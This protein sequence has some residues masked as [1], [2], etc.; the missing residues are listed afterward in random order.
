[1]FTVD[2]KIKDA[3]TLYTNK[4][5]EVVIEPLTALKKKTQYISS[6]GSKETSVDGDLNVLG[7]K[8]KLMIF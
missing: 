8:W 3:L 2:G 1:M 6:S 4:L 7:G 5:K